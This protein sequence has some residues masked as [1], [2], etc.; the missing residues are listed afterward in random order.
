MID[1]GYVER[2]NAPKQIDFGSIFI[3][4]GVSDRDVYVRDCINRNTVCVIS[5]IGNIIHYDCAVTNEVIQNIDFPSKEG[6]LGSKV[7]FVTDKIRQV[8]IVIGTLRM[9]NS[10]T[11]YNQQDVVIERFSKEGSTLFGTFL[12]SFMSILRVSGNKAVNIFIQAFGDI[13]SLLKLESSGNVE[14]TAT[15]SVKITGCKAVEIKNYDPNV[16]QNSTIKMT[17]ELIQ[18][19]T[20]ENGG[21]INIEELVARINTDI[22]NPLNEFIS[23]YKSHTHTDSAQGTTTTPLPPS[24]TITDATELDRKDFED[25]VV[26]H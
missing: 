16:E 24:S 8:P 3:P 7:V 23:K 12:H 22:V 9:S 10:R 18:L 20:G 2:P 5:D 1:F 11:Y 21:L 15:D 4:Y 14:T 26:T 17:P 13:K 6:E 25:T 19:N